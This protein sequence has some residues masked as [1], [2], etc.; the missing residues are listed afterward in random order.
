MRKEIK[1]LNDFQ[2]SKVIIDHIKSNNYE[3]HDLDE[4]LSAIKE[5]YQTDGV[6]DSKEKLV[7]SMLERL[8]KVN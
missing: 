7:F 2:K 1:K 3:Q 6:Y 8:L 4:M 5:L